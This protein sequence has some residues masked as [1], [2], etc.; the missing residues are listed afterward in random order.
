MNKLYWD[1]LIQ[2]EE[3]NARTLERIAN[4]LEKLAKLV[5]LG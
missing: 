5:E 4:A 2:L 1:T 3:D